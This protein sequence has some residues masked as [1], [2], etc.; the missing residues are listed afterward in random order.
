MKNKF[1]L[2]ALTCS[3]AVIGSAVGM[4]KDPS[5]YA[6]NKWRIMMDSMIFE[7]SNDVIKASRK[8]H[9]Q[10][11]YIRHDKKNRES[12]LVYVPIWGEA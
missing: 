5:K 3:A 10:R 7:S 12:V 6:Q 8:Y 11:L 1:I 4:N 2:A 9:S